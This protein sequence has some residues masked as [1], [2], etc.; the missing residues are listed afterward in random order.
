MLAWKFLS[1]GRFHRVVAI[2]RYLL[3]EM[4]STKTV[5]CTVPM[6]TIRIV[7]RISSV[8]DVCRLQYIANFVARS[9]FHNS[10][11]KNPF[12]SGGS[13]SVIRA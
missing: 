11:G 5:R 2:A 6:Q 7:V 8:C 1:F 13:K 9:T 4:A 3:G 12:I 10:T